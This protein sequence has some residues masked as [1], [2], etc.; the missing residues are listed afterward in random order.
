[1]D[2]RNPN[3]ISTD[4]KIIVVGNAGNGKTSFVNRWTKNTFSDSY[5]ATIVSEFAYKIYDDG[6]GKFYRIQLWDLAG[7][8]KSINIT[9]IFCRDAH[10]IVI[11]SDVTNNTSLNET[12]KWK[13]T[14]SENSKFMDGSEIPVILVENKI[15]LLNEEEIKDDKSSIDFAMKN[16]YLRSFRVSAKSGINVNESMD[17][18]IKYIITKLSL[19]NPKIEDKR[20]KN[21]NIKLNNNNNNNLDKKDKG[22]CC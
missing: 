17:F 8:D 11:L 18:L 6:K 5:K 9:K 21:N 3:T 12:I 2:K 1:M 22:S 13:N 4:L 14:I 15:D 19:L 7:Q 16:S 10:G 20:N